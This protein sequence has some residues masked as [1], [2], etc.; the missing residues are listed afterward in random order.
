MSATTNAAENR[1]TYIGASDC[2]AVL[3]MSRW[4]TP[5][6]IWAEKTG[7][8]EQEDISENLELEGAETDCRGV[9]L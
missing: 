6:Q 1:Q 4:K 7:A 2:A 8:L 5:I 3:G 9:S